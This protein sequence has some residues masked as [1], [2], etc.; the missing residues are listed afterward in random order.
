MSDIWHCMK[1]TGHFHAERKQ[2]LPVCMFPH[3]NGQFASYNAKYPTVFFGH[4]R[5]IEGPAPCLEIEARVDFYRI[6]SIDTIQDFLCKLGMKQVLPV[7]TCYLFPF[8]FRSALLKTSRK[9]PFFHEIFMNKLWWNIWPSICFNIKSITLQ[10]PSGKS[11][12]FAI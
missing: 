1:Q 12:S 4:C 2:V 3:K 10:K 7:S 11:T 9:H 8:R 6:P 5:K